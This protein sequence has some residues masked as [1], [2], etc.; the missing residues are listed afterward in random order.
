MIGSVKMSKKAVIYTRTSSLTNSADDRDSKIRQEKLCRDYCQKS[1]FEVDAVFYDQGVSGTL[2]VFERNEF[3]EMYIYCVKN[4]IQHIVFENNTRFSRD[5]IEQE[6]AF[7]RLKNEGFR[8]FSA[9]G[10]ELEDSAQSEMIRQIM[11]AVAEYERKSIVFRLAV[12]K[13]RK[14]AE[15]KKN[16]IVSLTGKGKVGGRKSHSDIDKDLVKLVKRLRR[17]NWKT[18]RQNSYR[19]IANILAQEYGQFNAKGNVFHASSIKSMCNQ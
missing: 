9:A 15:N 18:K 14:R 13:D 10:G 2:S 12:A 1:N 7:D 11:G 3:K 17:R 19:K 6:L 16:G 8:L 4:E 5:L